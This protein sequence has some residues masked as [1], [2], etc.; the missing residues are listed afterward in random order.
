MRASEFVTASDYVY[1]LQLDLY[2][3]GYIIYTDKYALMTSNGDKTHLIA[4]NPAENGYK[5]GVGEEARFGAIHG[6]THISK[7]L[8][9]VV[10]TSNHCLRVIER[11]TR[12]TSV[13]SGICRGSPGYQDGRL[14]RF[15]LPLSVVVDQK[16][17][18]QLHVTDFFNKAVRTVNVKSRIVS[19][20]VKSDSFTRLNFMTQHKQTGDLYVTPDRSVFKI[21]YV[22]KKITLIS[23]NPYGNDPFKELYGLIFISHDTLLLADYSNNKLRLLDTHTHEATTLNVSNASNNLRLPISILLTDNCLYVGQ[24]HQIVKYQCKYVLFQ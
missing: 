18:H 5:G 16:D 7:R 19:T 10:D 4:G 12:S 3:P 2:Q 11:T 23:A 22:T 1:H 24:F 15:N 9:V 20:F 17:K 13:L 6:I 8:V 14:A 21:A